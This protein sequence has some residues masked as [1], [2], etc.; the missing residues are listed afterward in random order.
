MADIAL[1]GP[2]PIELAP[3]DILGLL[4]DGIYEYAD[5]A[6]KQFDTAGVGAV[7]AEHHRVSMTELI[8]RIRQAVE[9]HA[10]GAPQMDDMTIVFIKRN[11]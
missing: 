5:H 4:S 1:D 9:L 2:P 3:G 11:P 10:A 6:G 7:I 8:A